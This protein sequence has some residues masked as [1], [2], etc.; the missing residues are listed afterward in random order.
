MLD[1]LLAYPRPAE[2]SP[3]AYTPLSILFPA[4][5]FE[6]E[7][8]SVALVGRS[9]CG[10]STLARMILA[11]DRR[12]ADNVIALRAGQWNKKEFSKARGLFGRTLGL[13]GVGKIG[14]EMIPR[15]KAFGMPVMAWSRSLTT[16]KAALLGVERKESPLEVAAAADVEIGRLDRLEASA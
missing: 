3:A 16:E 8:Q 7:G 9:G 14:Q 15:A 10:K 4:A 12:V 5:L 6:A 2:E 13:V 11:L 1:Y